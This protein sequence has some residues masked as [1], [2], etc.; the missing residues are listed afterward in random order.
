MTD[1]LNI[2]TMETFD[3]AQQLRDKAD[4]VEYLR[5]VLEEGGE[6]RICRCLGPYCQGPRDDRNSPGQRHPAGSPV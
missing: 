1:N 5:Q 6:R 3:M 4:V 2:N